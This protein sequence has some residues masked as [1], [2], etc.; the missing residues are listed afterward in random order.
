MIYQGNQIAAAKA[1]KD[2]D[3]NH[4]RVKEIQACF[5]KSDLRRLFADLP[6]GFH[7]VTVEFQGSLKTGG[8]FR[9]T[10]H[11]F[12]LVLGFDCF[13]LKASPNPLNPETVLSFATS[14]PGPVTVQIFDV[15]GRL[16]KSLYNGTMQAGLNE[17]R[18]DGRSTTGTRVATG[19]YFVKTRTVD[20]EMVERLT[21]LK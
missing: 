12:V 15:R 1:H 6:R 14:R 17:V 3:K 2:G 7:K 16:V 8:R 5:E 4:N 19:V 20:A 11:H 21:V 10:A 18:W 9:D 13:A